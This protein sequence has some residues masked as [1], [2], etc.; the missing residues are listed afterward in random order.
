M[1]RSSEA[2]NLARTRC[3]GVAKGTYPH[4]VESGYTLSRRNTGSDCP[5]AVH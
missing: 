1:Q 5:P 3:V 2:G 4:R